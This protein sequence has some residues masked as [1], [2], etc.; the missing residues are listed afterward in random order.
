MLFSVELRDQTILQKSND[1]LSTQSEE[2]HLP[3]VRLLDQTLHYISNRQDGRLLVGSCRLANTGY[4]SLGN[5][6][7]VLL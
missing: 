7:G 4:R 1:S 3:S 2:D 6:T 5:S